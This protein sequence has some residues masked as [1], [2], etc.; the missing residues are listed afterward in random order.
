MRTATILRPEVATTMLLTT[1]MLAL[2]GFNFESS[3]EAPGGAGSIFNQVVWPLLLVATLVTTRPQI[4]PNLITILGASL[5]MIMFASAVDARDPF[6]SI[7][8]V[9][10]QLTVTLV[11]FANS[12]M[13]D[14]IGM[15]RVVKSY[16]VLTF[17][18]NLIFFVATP[19]SIFDHDGSLR[20]AYA[21]KNTAG[22]AFFA[23][24]LSLFWLCTSKFMRS[25]LLSLLGSLLFSGLLY[26]THSKTCATL[27]LPS[28]VSIILFKFKPL[29]RSAWWIV[30]CLM[31]GLCWFYFDYIWSLRSDDFTGRVEVW[32]Q[33]IPIALVAPWVGHGFGSFW[34]DLRPLYFADAKNSFLYMLNSAHSGYIDFSL[35]SGL[36][37]TFLYCALVI[38]VTYRIRLLGRSNRL[39]ALIVTFALSFIVYNALESA[40]FVVANAMWPFMLL[41]SAASSRQIRPARDALVDYAIRRWPE[42]GRFGRQRLAQ[43]KPGTGFLMRSADAIHP[44]N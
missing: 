23:A 34:E 35:S 33:T 5:F 19:S 18:I 9:L 3:A 22:A 14:E 32:R 25:R 36:I 27:L 44:K 7:K 40:I 28:M 30:S 31:A 37:S 39:P 11:F 41:I 29:A 20:G 15:A 43:S 17:L 12:H 13:L 4:S 1:G 6:V 38:A 16:A 42:G 10:F 21:H 26:L 2:S 24:A 8:R